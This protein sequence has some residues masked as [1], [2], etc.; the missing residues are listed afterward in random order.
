MQISNK[1]QVSNDRFAYKIEQLKR[2]LNFIVQACTLPRYHIAD[3][4]EIVRLSILYFAICGQR[5]VVGL[6]ANLLGMQKK[7]ASLCN[8]CIL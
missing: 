6:E 2:Q 4:I 7:R 3:L 5:A 8:L 1:T